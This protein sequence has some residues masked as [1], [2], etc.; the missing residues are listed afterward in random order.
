MDVLNKGLPESIKD[1]VFY[2]IPNQSEDY[3]ISKEG[4]VISLRGKDRM[5]K[6]LKGSV[7]SNGYRYVTLSREGDG[8]SVSY[9]LHRLVGST[10]INNPENYP[11]INHKDGDKL[12]NKV[13][14]LEWCTYKENNKHARLNNLNNNVGESH[15]NATLSDCEV[16]V[17][18]KIYKKG[19]LTQ[20][21]I[22]SLFNIHEGTVSKIILRTRRN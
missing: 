10:F 20:N 14:N 9:L 3:R 11:V 4:I 21:Q 13:E 7:K 19:M 5:C 17:I 16:E 12:N 22:A 1:V 15:I 2:K 6:V 18:R 8:K